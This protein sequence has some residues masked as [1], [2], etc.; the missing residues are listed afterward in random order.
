MNVV[1]VEPFID[2]IYRIHKAAR[3]QSLESKITLIQNAISDKRNEIKLLTHHPKNIGGQTMLNNRHQVF[4]QSDKNSNKYMVETILFDDIIPYLP[5]MSNGSV[6]K[7]A[8]MKIDIEGFEPFAFQQASKLFDTLDIRIIFMEWGDKHKHFANEIQIVLDMVDFLYSRNF[9][10]Y[11][12]K[13]AAL[14][15]DWNTWPQDVIWKKEFL[16]RDPKKSRK[17]GWSLVYIFS[18]ERRQL[19]K[20]FIF[21]E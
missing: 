6:Y 11:D 21:L 13:M 16:D 9:F 8:M 2:N 14:S 19:F 3:N 7:R 1:T 20:L 15:A 18:S 4:N 10:I 17:I 12:V 5:K